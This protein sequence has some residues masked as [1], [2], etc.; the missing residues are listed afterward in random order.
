MGLVVALS[1]LAAGCGTGTRQSLPSDT[2]SVTPPPLSAEGDVRRTNKGRWV[3]SEWSALPGWNQD[4]LTAAWPALLR[5]CERM[6]ATAAGRR[7]HGTTATATNNNAANLDTANPALVA[8][9]WQPTCAAAR[10]LG[11]ATDEAQIRTFLTQRLEPWRI[12]SPEGRAEGLLT[13]YFEPEIEASRVKTDRH[14]VPVYALPPALSGRGNSS[15]WYTRQQIETLPEVQSALSGR[16]IAWVSDPLD[17]LMLQIQGSGRLLLSPQGA[18]TKA[19]PNVIRV[20]YAGNNGQPY[21][22]IGAWLVGQGAMTLE[23]ANWPAIRQ[24]AKANPQRVGEMIQTNPRYVFF[25]ESP[26]LDPTVGANG[27]QGLPLTPER[28][29]AVDRESIPFGTPVWLAS[30]EPQPWSPNGTPSSR[31]MQRLVMAQDTGSAIVGAVRADFYWGWGPGTEERAGRTKQPL[32]LWA[33][34]PR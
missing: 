9:Y 10:Q 16:E 30:T 28:S 24:W 3:R 18:A 19:P 15:P 29:I 27:A 17:A 14:T 31:P 11:S 20:A 23:Q 12:E 21:R 26:L 8:A 33:L 22:S 5:S 7:T 25:K 4:T 32:R 6:L 34:W 2:P 1:L 13:G